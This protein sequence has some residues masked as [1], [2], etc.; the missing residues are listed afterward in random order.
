MPTIKEIRDAKPVQPDANVPA[1]KTVF[2]LDLRLVLMVI[3]G[4]YFIIRIV[5]LAFDVPFL[6]IA[7]VVV[8]GGVVG[9][10]VSFLFSALFTFLLVGCLLSLR[11][12]ALAC[13]GGN[14]AI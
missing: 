8:G 6:L 3:L 4:I 12:Y 9:P 14:V 5:Y 10:L 13:R 1:P 11:A 7:Q 2:N